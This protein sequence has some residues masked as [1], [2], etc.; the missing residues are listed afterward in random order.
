MIKYYHVFFGKP[1]IGKTEF[2]QN[3]VVDCINIITKFETL[4]HSPFLYSQFKKDITQCISNKDIVGVKQKLDKAFIDLNFAAD[5]NNYLLALED[6]A[7]LNWG[8]VY[9]YQDYIYPAIWNRFIFTELYKDPKDE[10]KMLSELK[11]KGVQSCLKTIENLNVIYN[12]LCRLTADRSIR[13]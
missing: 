5:L 3:N 12:S 4:F 7:N 1:Y 2:L 11:E 9:L 13:I 10:Q 8:S 6:G